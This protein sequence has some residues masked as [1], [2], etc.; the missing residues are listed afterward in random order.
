MTAAEPR[1]EL[2]DF[3]ELLGRELAAQRLDRFGEILA[4]FAA[5]DGVVRQ[6]LREGKWLRLGGRCCVGMLGAF[7][8]GDQRIGEIAPGIELLGAPS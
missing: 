5:R 8:H 2:G 6:M 1:F 3:I 4:G 7:G